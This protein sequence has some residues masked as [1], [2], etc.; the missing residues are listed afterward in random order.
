[1]ELTFLFVLNDVTLSI[2][3]GQFVAFVGVSGSGKS[4]L[5][6]LLLG[7]ET[8]EVGAIYYDGQD[9]STLDIR[10]VRRQLGVIVL[11]SSRAQNQSI[12][13]NIIGFEAANYQKMLGKLHVWPASMTI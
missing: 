6:R 1:M 10:A 9:L 4:T 7:F 8:P 3:P 11:Q 5:F 13:R 12:F 2:L